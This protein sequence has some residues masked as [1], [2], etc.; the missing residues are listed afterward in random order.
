MQKLM[1]NGQE[2]Q[3]DVPDDMPLLWVLRD[4]MGLTGTKYG[5]GIAQCGVCTVHLDGQAVRSCVLPVSAVAGRKVTT[6]EAVGEQAIGQAV[7]KAWLEHEVVQCGYCQSGQIMS[8]VALL[9]EHPKANDEQIVNAMSGNL[10]RCATYT[11]IR[12]A[13]KS[14]SQA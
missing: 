12:A 1:I 3:L 2:H 11:R 9:Q 6:I 7:Q 10:C 14:V 8:A 4:V 5:C 13:I